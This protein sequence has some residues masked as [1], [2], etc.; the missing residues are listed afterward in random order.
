METKVLYEVLRS[1][2]TVIGLVTFLAVIV[3]AFWPGNKVEFEKRGRIPFD[4]R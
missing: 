2:W 3:W 1:A 4:E